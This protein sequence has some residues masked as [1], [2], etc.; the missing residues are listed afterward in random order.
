[1]EDVAKSRGPTPG[2]DRAHEGGGPRGL[3]S[4]PLFPGGVRACHWR[5]ATGAHLHRWGLGSHFG[6][7]LRDSQ[8]AAENQEL[9]LKSDGSGEAGKDATAIAQYVGTPASLD[10][11]CGTHNPFYGS[12]ILLNDIMERFGVA[13]NEPVLRVLF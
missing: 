4:G 12:T 13:N 1:V 7:E 3:Y 9:K 5:V 6:Y 10:A 2:R 8:R 11:E